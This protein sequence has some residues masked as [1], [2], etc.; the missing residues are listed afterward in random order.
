MRNQM[1][2][3]SRR[4]ALKLFKERQAMFVNCNIVVRQ[5]AMKFDLRRF[6]E[7]RV[8]HAGNKLAEFALLGL[9][10]LILG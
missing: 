2:D 8:H 3:D 9:D 1:L 10:L 7:D 6:L 4:L 5:L